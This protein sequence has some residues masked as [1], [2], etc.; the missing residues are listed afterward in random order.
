M[1]LH[2]LVCIGPSGSYKNDGAQWIL[3]ADKIYMRLGAALSYATDTPI[4]LSQALVLAITKKQRKRRRRRYSVHLITAPGKCLQRLFWFIWPSNRLFRNST[5]GKFD[6]LPGL[7]NDGANWAPPGG[8]QHINH[9]SARRLWFAKVLNDSFAG[10]GQMLARTL[11]K[12]QSS[13]QKALV[14]WAHSAWCL[15]IYEQS[16]NA[17]IYLAETEQEEKRLLD[18]FSGPN[19]K[20]AKKCSA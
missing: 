7:H 8:M 13:T 14:H 19:N 5:L 4:W 18:H 1:L 17:L 16:S 10:P 15:Y 9:I 2:L 3:F 12:L 20:L 11:A 6:K